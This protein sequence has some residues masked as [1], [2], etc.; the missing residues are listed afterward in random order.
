MS[1]IMKWDVSDIVE[2]KIIKE[3]K[4]DDVRINISIP[5]NFYFDIKLKL[6]DIIKIIGNIE[7]SFI[8]IKFLHYYI[9]NSLVNDININMPKNHII[10]NAMSIEYDILDLEFSPSST[11]TSYNNFYILSDSKYESIS[12]I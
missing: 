4:N 1:S 6:S 5:D 2:K 8:D 7:S 3:L 9:V 12:V 10:V 11:L